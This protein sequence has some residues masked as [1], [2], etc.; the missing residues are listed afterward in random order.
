MTDAPTLKELPQVAIEKKID[1]GEDS[2]A[3]HEKGVDGFVDPGAVLV[4]LEPGS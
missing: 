4:L 3:R 2:F 1:L